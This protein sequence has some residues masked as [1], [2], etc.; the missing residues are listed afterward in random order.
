MQ[1]QLYLTAQEFYL[2]Q[3][4]DPHDS[5]RDAKPT[6]LLH[7]ACLKRLPDIVQ[8]LLDKKMDVNLLDYNFATALDDAAFSGSVSCAKVLVSNGADHR[9][10]NCDG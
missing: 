5:E 6:T 7:Y 2:D 4:L 3:M 8:Y 10:L 9:K 1:V